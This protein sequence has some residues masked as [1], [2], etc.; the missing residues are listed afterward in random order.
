[1][2]ITFSLMFVAKPMSPVRLPLPS[3]TII[4]V[5]LMILTVVK[6][7]RAENTYVQIGSAILYSGCGNRKKIY[8]Y[9]AVTL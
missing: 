6:S 9:R 4:P 2:G 5:S 1:M 7:T 8:I 3:N